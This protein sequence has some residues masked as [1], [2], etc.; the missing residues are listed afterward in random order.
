MKNMN[1]FSKH[2]AVVAVVIPHVADRVDVDEEA[3]AGD[4][5]QHDQRKLVEIEAEVNLKLPERSQWRDRNNKEPDADEN[6]SHPQ[7]HGKGGAAE[8]E[9]DRRDRFLRRPPAKEAIDRRPCQGK[10][11]MSQR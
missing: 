4:H 6:R 10:N 7:R 11:G 1:R 5:Q 2:E 3:D 9:R 8:N